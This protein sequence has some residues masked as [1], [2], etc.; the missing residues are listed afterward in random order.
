MKIISIYIIIL[1][2]LTACGLKGIQVT[3]VTNES[4]YVLSVL[5]ESGSEIG[6]DSNITLGFSKPVLEESVTI[7]SL[8][9]L[10]KSV[11]DEYDLSD[12]DDLYD[13]V[14]DGDVEVVSS[15]FDV[16]PG[17]QIVTISFQKEDLSEEEY[18]AV[19]LP[20]IQSEDH[21]PLDQTA[22]GEEK[23]SFS[24]SF[25]VKDKEVLVDESITEGSYPEVPS[26]DEVVEPEIE[27]ESE[28]D[29]FDWARVLI[30][31][32]VTDPQQDH[33]ESGEGNGILFDSTPGTGTIGS[34]DEYIEIFNGTEES[35]NI[36]AWSLNMADGTDESQMLSEG[37]DTYFSLGGDIDNISSGE[38]LVLGNP[39]GSMNNSISIELLDEAGEIVDFVDVKDANASGIEDEAYYRDS[40][41][42]WIQGEGSLGG[43]VN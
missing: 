18:I 22:I 33:S 4:F 24:S 17:K 43:F 5:P 21:Y 29:P 16:D 19:A 6:T 40:D 35:L 39:D 26:F 31:E 3:D 20:M 28:S 32:L 34:T 11:Y 8:F 37:W 12:W 14:V 42:M 23:K 36:S 13:D 1:F 38:F 41:G 27:T 9:I 30:T 25:L 7:Q 2:A 15:S 10:E